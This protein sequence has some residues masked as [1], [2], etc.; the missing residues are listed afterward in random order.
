MKKKQPT[1]SALGSVRGSEENFDDVGNL[2]PKTTKKI[3][4]SKVKF[5]KG[6]LNDN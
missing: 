1:P 3:A 6:A 5:V 4:S 2:V